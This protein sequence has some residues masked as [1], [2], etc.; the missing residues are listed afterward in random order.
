MVTK[1]SK[2]AT[3]SNVS[4]F[5]WKFNQSNQFIAKKNIKEKYIHEKFRKQTKNHK[6]HTIIA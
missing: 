3:G 1:S 4:A 6:K 2:I 5:D